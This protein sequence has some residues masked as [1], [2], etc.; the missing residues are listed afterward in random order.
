MTKY[1]V[2]LSETTHGTATVEAA[3]Q[4]EAEAKAWRL[5]EDV[6]LEAFGDFNPQGTECQVDSQTP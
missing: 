1:T 5:L 3:S 6:G 2:Y 4:A